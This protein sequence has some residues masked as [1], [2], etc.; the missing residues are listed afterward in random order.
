M[1]MRIGHSWLLA[2]AA[3]GCSTAHSAAP[4]GNIDWQ[5]PADVKPTLLVHFVGRE[6]H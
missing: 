6:R 5:Q 3:V 4:K 2:L 1:K